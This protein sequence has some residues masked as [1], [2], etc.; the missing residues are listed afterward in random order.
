MVSRT[1][2]TASSTLFSR[3][4][5]NFLSSPTRAPSIPR[6]IGRDAAL[7]HAVAV[8]CCSTGRSGRPLHLPLSAPESA[9]ISGRDRDGISASDVFNRSIRRDD[10]AKDLIRHSPKGIVAVAA[11]ADEGSGKRVVKVPIECRRGV[12]LDATV[13]PAEEI[14][15]EGV[16]RWRAWCR[17]YEAWHYHGPAER[18]RKAHCQDSSSP[19]WRSGYNIATSGGTSTLARWCRDRASHPPLGSSSASWT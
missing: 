5:P 4:T 2:R 6:F 3:R 17:H 12:S 7:F 10:E 1:F 16:T 8:V 13:L 15:V 11:A 18:A 14:V 19:Y 9:K